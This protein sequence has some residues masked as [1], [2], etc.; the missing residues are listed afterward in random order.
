[1]NVKEFRTFDKIIKKLIKNTTTTD[2]KH[3]NEIWDNTEITFLGD[4]NEG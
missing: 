2:E 4:R 3:L 1:M